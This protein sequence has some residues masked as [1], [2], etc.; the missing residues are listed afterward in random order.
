[1]HF[2][3]NENFLVKHL[4]NDQ[5]LLSDPCRTMLQ[6]IK[7]QKIADLII[8]NNEVFSGRIG[9]STASEVT[10]TCMIDGSVQPIVDQKAKA[11]TIEFLKGRKH[12]KRFAKSRYMNCIIER[13]PNDEPRTWVS[14]A[15]IAPKSGSEDI[16]LCIDMH[17]AN[18]AIKRPYTQIPTMEDIVHKF[19]SAEDFTKLEIIKGVLSSI[20]TKQFIKIY[21]RLL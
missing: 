3:Y 8:S 12:D 10:L 5:K 15:V 6:G 4:I 18:M 7:C 2:K 9:K 13:V 21:Y 20:C 16:R 11:N 1:M 14:P 19:Q 17:M